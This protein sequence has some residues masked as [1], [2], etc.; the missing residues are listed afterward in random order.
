MQK[1]QQK[2]VMT[3]REAASGGST[4]L[5]SPPNGT[6]VMHDFYGPLLVVIGSAT[7]LPVH[8]KCVGCGRVQASAF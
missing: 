2:P 1:K 5:M 6:E 4:S 8:P 7:T 3:P